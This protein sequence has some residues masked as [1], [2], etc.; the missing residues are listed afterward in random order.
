MPYVRD[1]AH[2]NQRRRQQFFPERA[3]SE[4]GGRLPVIFFA[5]STG[6]STSVFGGFNGQNEKKNR[7]RRGHGPPLPMAAYTYDDNSP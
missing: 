3:P 4:S 6:G 7:P 2:E 1:T 5:N